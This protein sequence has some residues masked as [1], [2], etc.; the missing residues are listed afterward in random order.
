[1]DADIVALRP[2]LDPWQRLSMDT[3]MLSIDTF[4]TNTDPLRTSVEDPYIPSTDWLPLASSTGCHVNTSS[5]LHVVATSSEIRLPDQSP[6]HSKQSL[7]KRSCQCECS[8]TRC[9]H[10]LHC[11]TGWVRDFVTLIRL[12]GWGLDTCICECATWG[13][14]TRHDLLACCVCGENEKHRKGSVV[15]GHLTK[16]YKLPSGAVCTY[17]ME[18]VWD[19]NIQLQFFM[20]WLHV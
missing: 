19:I 1:M 13:G 14:E 6:D 3:Q 15:L 10:P 4:R 2:N 20:K 5:N 9:G 18:D 17:I 16:W 7:S 8:P 11:I 12:V